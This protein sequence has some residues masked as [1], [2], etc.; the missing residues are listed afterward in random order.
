MD[1]IDEDEVIITTLYSIAAHQGGFFS[2]NK[3]CML[4]LTNKR[5]AVI[6]KTD[7]NS[8][9]WHKALD[10]QKEAFRKGDKNTIRTSTYTIVD[11]NT[12]L[13]YENNLNI[14]FE[15]IVEL[16]NEKKRWAPELKIIF[17]E[18]KK[19]TK[20]INFALVRTW[21]RYPLPDPIEYEKPDWDQFIET[22][23]SYMHN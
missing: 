15:N 22:A 10:A 1:N 14:P 6:Y 13:D 21:I 18:K 17:R 11:L 20:S 16:K 9:K 8:T 7:M 4:C 2:R 12:D 23:K 19:H 5:I 3:E